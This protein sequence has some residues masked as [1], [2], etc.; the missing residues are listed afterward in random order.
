MPSAERTISKPFR[1]QRIHGKHLPARFL[2]NLHALGR[3]TLLT[4]D[5]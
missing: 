4:P 5:S 1:P 2:L 3:D